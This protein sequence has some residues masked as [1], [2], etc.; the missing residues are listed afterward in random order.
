MRRLLW[1]WHG[2][3]GLIAALPLFVI[4][5]TGSLLVFKAELDSLLMPEVV[6]ASAGTR[7]PMNQLVASAN[8]QLSGSEILGWQFGQTG[9]AD[10]LFVAAMGTYDWQKLWLDPASGSLLTPPVSLTWAIT[11]WLLDLH[12]MLLLDHAGLLIAGVMALLFLF[13]GISG[14][15]LHRQFWRTFFTLRWHKGLRLLL[16]DT[17]KMLGIVGA[18]IFLVLGFT[19]AWWNLEHFYEEELS[20]HDDSQYIISQNY[21]SP[22]L[23]FD[24]LLADTRRQLPAF[25]P[26]YLRL[27]D[28]SYPGV[29]FFGYRENGGVLRSR[30]GSIISYNDQSGAHTST[31]DV[32]GAPALYQFTDSFRPLHY[33]D[34][35]GLTTRILWCIIGFFPCLMALSGFWMW[36]QRS[37]RKAPRRTPVTA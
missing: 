33:G 37:G 4:A 36:R 12:Y 3:A 8:Q 27:P 20:G 10:T 16:S 7:L 21:Y 6:N 15:V 14:I 34:F 19:G 28:A 23:D 24:A 1:K 5:L 35:G 2:L 22:A 29:H 17:H 11:D 25:V 31:L 9:E 32:A 30:F 13:L 18:P 26:T